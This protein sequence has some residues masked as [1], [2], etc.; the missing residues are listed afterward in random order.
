MK[1]KIADP[2]TPSSI[3]LSRY[4]KFLVFNINELHERKI[5]KKSPY[6]K[7]DQFKEKNVV[8]AILNEKQTN[9]I[10]I[11]FARNRIDIQRKYFFVICFLGVVPPNFS[12]FF[13]F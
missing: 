2:E 6:Q 9:A 13:P 7:K 11:T 5:L 4:G 12:F 3:L 10:Q 8:R 1:S